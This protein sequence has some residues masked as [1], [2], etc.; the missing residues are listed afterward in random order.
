L[1]DKLPEIQD[2]FLNAKP[3]RKGGKLYMKVLVSHDCST[4]ELTAQ[5]D[6]FHQEVKERF[7]K[8]A[9][10][11]PH[12]ANAGWL[13][14]SLPYTDSDL[15]Q[16]EVTSKIDQQVELRWMIINDDTRTTGVDWNSLPKALHVFCDKKQLDYVQEQL[17]KIYGSKANKFPM[18]T[19][20]RFLKPIRSLC[21]QDSIMKYKVLRKDQHI[22]CKHAHRRTVTG[23]TD[24]ER[25][26]GKAR[27]QYDPQT[28]NPIISDGGTK[29]GW[30]HRSNPDLQGNRPKQMRSRL[31]L[32]FPSGH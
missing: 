8:C 7:K 5:T 19:K 1:P 10:Q 9:I 14:Y 24:L 22:W 11:V 23:I 20:M 17:S 15:L 2:I 27:R 16:Q 3:L 30:I 29:K 31:H 25:I 4:E 13:Q 12:T 21:N 18:K 26:S 32:Y 6:W 28:E